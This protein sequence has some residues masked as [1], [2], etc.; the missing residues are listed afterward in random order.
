MVQAKFFCYVAVPTNGRVSLQHVPKL[1][2]INF[3]PSQQLSI[4]CAESRPVVHPVK[5][6]ESFSAIDAIFVAIPSH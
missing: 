2:Q 6:W 1:I 3:I 5:F 4:R